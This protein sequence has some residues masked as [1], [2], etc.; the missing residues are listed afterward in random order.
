MFENLSERLLAEERDMALN[1]AAQK[2]AS[3]LGDEIPEITA[4]KLKSKLRYRYKVCCC[5]AAPLI[6]S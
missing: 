3:L 6:F 1:E 2:V 4:A 5:S